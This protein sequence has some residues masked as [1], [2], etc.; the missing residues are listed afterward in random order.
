MKEGR[1]FRNEENWVFGILVMYYLIREYILLM[2][3]LI[4][5]EMFLNRVVVVGIH[6]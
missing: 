2:L 3:K 6:N 5:N 4:K 1:D